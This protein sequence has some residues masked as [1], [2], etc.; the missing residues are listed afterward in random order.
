M[1]ISRINGGML[2][3]NLLRDGVDLS[4]DTD[5]IHLDVTNQRIGINTN[6]PDSDL[7]VIGI[8]RFSDIIAS[9]NVI[10]S[11]NTDQNL[12]YTPNGA[13]IN[14]LSS[15]GVAN[16]DSDSI[17]FTDGTI[18]RTLTT[19][20]NFAYTTGGGLNLQNDLT[21]G[22][23]H[24]NGSNISTTTGAGSINIITTGYVSSSNISLLNLTENRVPYTNSF[25][26]LIDNANFTFTASTNTLNVTGII[27]VDD[28][29]LDGSTISTASSEM[30]FTPFNNTGIVINDTSAVKMPSGVTGHRPLT[31]LAGHLRFNTS[32]NIL[33]YYNGTDWV[34]TASDFG[35]ITSEQF[36]GDDS[37]TI[38]TLATPAT[39]NSVLVIIQGVT[40]IPVAAYTVSGSTLTLTQAPALGDIIEVRTISSNYTITQ[41]ADT[42]GDTY[43]EVE[44]TT[45]DD[46]IRF[47]TAGTER[48]VIDENGILDASNAHSVQLPDYTVAEATALT[49]VVAG[50]TIYVSDGDAGQPCAAIYDGTTWKRVALGA[51]ISAV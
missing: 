6:S 2:S 47:T 26:N 16:L 18:N 30:I 51:T 24:I 48:V 19:D 27:T 5:L 31:P 36:T 21:V 10:S 8:S 37:T 15:A 20:S 32:N 42:D 33:E 9:T 43:I 23:L 22:A 46:N 17:V 50:Q 11:F 28:L 38:F 39:T 4:F 25:N 40:Q 13:G 12:Y 1:A 35:L 14:V 7:Q 41:V 45:D 34:S 44:S 29:K 3:S 49:N